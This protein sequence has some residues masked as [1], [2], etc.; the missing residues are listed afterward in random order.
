MGVLHKSWSD[1]MAWCL[2]EGKYSTKAAPPERVVKPEPVVVKPEPVADI[3]IQAPP[4]RVGNVNGLQPIPKWT[5]AAKDGTEIFC[6][7][8]SRT[9]RVYSFSW[10]MRAC[11]HCLA[12]VKKAN[13][14]IAVDASKPRRPRRAF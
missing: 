11:R 13:W 1:F 7:Q 12:K 3:K 9:T 10:S 6:P 5:H 4:E 8:C 2:G 14:L